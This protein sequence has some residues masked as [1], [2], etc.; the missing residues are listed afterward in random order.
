MIVNVHGRF[1]EEE[2]PSSYPLYLGTCDNRQYISFEY[3]AKSYDEG[4]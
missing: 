1:S 4:A 2:L 3:T